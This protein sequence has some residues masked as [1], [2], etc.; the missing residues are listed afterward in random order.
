M[1]AYYSTIC[2]VNIVV[3]T[4]KYNWSMSTEVE[5]RKGL[6]LDGCILTSEAASYAVT[7][8][9]HLS[10]GMVSSIIE[11]VIGNSIT[12]GWSQRLLWLRKRTVYLKRPFAACSKK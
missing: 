7:F 2:V 5:E 1:P 12:D 9:R 6:T 4:Q 3:S 10:D 8:A 11:D